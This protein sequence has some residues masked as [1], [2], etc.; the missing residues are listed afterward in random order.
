MLS[1]KQTCIIHF[2]WMVL[3]IA[4][5]SA[6]RDDSDEECQSPDLVVPHERLE[7]DEELRLHILGL[8]SYWT[9]LLGFSQRKVKPHH[10]RQMADPLQALPFQRL[11]YGLLFGH[12]QVCRLQQCNNLLIIAYTV[13]SDRVHQ[14]AVAPDGKWWQGPSLRQ[15]PW[16]AWRKW[17]KLKAFHVC[18]F[19]LQLPHWVTITFGK[20]SR[21]TG[22]ISCD[23]CHHPPMA[24][25]MI[26]KTSRRCSKQLVFLGSSRQE[27]FFYIE[28][29]EQNIDHY[30]CFMVQEWSTWH[31]EQGPSDPRKRL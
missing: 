12:W 2:F 21:A 22:R 28:H 1:H 7:D 6:G 30:H 27:H 19:N 11:A 24:S 10:N 14:N 25:A 9:K 5:E 13:P 3:E 26:V 4:L 16:L 17:K 23:F 15:A 20:P 8:Q 31:M 18:L 29:I